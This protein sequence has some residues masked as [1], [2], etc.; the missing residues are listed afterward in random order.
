MSTDSSLRLWAISD[1]HLA[2]EVNR[3]ALA[4]IP[5]HGNDWLILAGDIAEREELLVAALELLADRFGQV[6]WVPG[7]HDLWTDRRPGAV[8]RRGESRYRHLV[9]L[10]RGIGVLTP[11]DPFPRWPHDLD[12]APVF[13]APLFLLYDYSFRPADIPLSELKSW[14]RQKHAVPADELLLDPAPYESRA[15]WCAAR[16]AEAEERLTDL[17]AEARTILVNHWPLREDLIRIPRVPRFLPWCGTRRTH[18][19]HLRFRAVEVVTG[20]LHTRRT[21]VVD[22][23]SFHEVSLGYPRQ[24]EHARGIAAY[25]RDVTPGRRGV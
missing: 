12:G 10:A 8:S 2:S 6:I 19:W 14:V 9:D 20:H 15:D 4:E 5:D 7:N 23:T 21:D 22:G 3:S 11:E 13:V 1:L 25:L 17:P 24:W 16:C 18:D